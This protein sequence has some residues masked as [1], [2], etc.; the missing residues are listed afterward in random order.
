MKFEGWFCDYDNSLSFFAVDEYYEQSRKLDGPS[1]VKV[2]ECETETW[3]E[4][5]VLW[6]EFNKWE[7]YVPMLEEGKD[8]E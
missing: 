6:H 2:F 5:I 4:A 8:N 3:E 1:A 7:P